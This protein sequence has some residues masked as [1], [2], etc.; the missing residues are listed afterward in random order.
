MSPLVDVQG[1]SVEY[2]RRGRTKRALRDV[3]LDVRPGETVGLVGESGSG[4]TTLGRALLGQV[5]VSSGRILFDGAEISAYTARQRRGLA[6][7]I[8]VVFQNPYSSLNPQR[9]IA[10]S[11]AET[12]TTDKELSSD[13]V[14]ARVLET[15]EHVGVPR[16][17]ADRYPGSFSGGQRQRIAIARALLPRPDLVVCD[18]AVSALDL[19]IQAQVLNLLVELQDELGLAYLFITHDLAIVRHLCH[20]MVVLKDG[21]VVERG[22]TADVCAAPRDPYTRRLLESAPVADPDA[23]LSASAAQ[24]QLRA[25]LVSPLKEK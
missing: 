5:A 10:E 11:V 22:E 23:Q 21:A 19:S 12:L 14:R 16:Q 6:Q 24:R 25:V 15:L 9:T 2:G 3:S 7:R 17:A 8:Q 4:K 18:E 13:E 1:V 20:R